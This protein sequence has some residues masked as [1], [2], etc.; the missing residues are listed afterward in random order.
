[1]P[2]LKAGIDYIGVGGGA[3]IVNDQKE[4]LLLKR[5]PKAKNDQGKWERPGGTVEFGEKIEDMIKREIREE[6]GLEIEI[7]KMLGYTDHFIETKNS[8]WVSFGFLAKIIK[9]EPKVMEPGKHEDIAW[10]PLDNL[11]ENIAQPTLEGISE[12]LKQSN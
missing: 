8:H 11:P 9:G 6:T 2:E 7:I 5:G 10:F 3:L 4:V 1:M 12:Y